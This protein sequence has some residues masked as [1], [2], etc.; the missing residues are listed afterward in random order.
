MRRVV[1]GDESVSAPLRRNYD[2][3]LAAIARQE[4]MRIRRERKRR[5]EEELEYAAALDMMIFDDALVC[6]YGHMEM[7]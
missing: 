1:H 6:S 7:F 2:N 4:R 5:R 3:I